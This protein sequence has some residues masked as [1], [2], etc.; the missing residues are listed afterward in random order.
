[1][2]SQWNT[3]ADVFCTGADVM[4]SHS[5][6]HTGSSH[7]AVYVHQ[8]GGKQLSVGGICQIV[9]R[10]PC[11]MNDNKPGCVQQLQFAKA[12]CI[13]P[14]YFF[15]KILVF[16]LFYSIFHIRTVDLMQLHQWLHDISQGGFSVGNR[17]PCQCNLL[18]GSFNFLQDRRT[19]EKKGQSAFS[20]VKR[21][22]KDPHSRINK[23]YFNSC[24][25]KNT[26][27]SRSCTK[28]Y[29][30]ARI[31]TSQCEKLERKYVLENE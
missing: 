22:N 14:V 15:T 10:S 2:L 31:C 29:A 30:G 27:R 23:N 21:L 25:L 5:E 20:V 24:R 17:G 9:F 12:L 11:R 19:I 16:I 18:N 7:P 26:Q 13:K 4:G 6:G 28:M 8:P 3:I 1:M